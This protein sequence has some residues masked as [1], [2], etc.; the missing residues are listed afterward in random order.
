MDKQDSTGIDDLREEL[1][2]NLYVREGRAFVPA[3]PEVVQAFKGAHSNTYQVS[4]YFGDWFSSRSL[5]LACAASLQR[6]FDHVQVITPDR[7]G[8]RIHPHT[9]G[10]A[11]YVDV[12]IALHVQGN[13]EATVQREESD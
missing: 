10:K 11:W 1:V 9:H 6:I 2:P 5:A 4:L 7:L 13:D 12:S 3:S 8:V